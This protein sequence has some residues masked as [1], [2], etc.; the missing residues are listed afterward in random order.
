ME[1]R[2]GGAMGKYPA[3]QI[4]NLKHHYLLLTARSASYNLYPLE[5]RAN[6]FLSQ[7]LH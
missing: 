4:I 7:K 1:G 6:A 5:Y 3:K 2:S